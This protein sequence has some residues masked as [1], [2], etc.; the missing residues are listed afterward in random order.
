MHFSIVGLC[1]LS[2]SYSVK[3][4]I[5]SFIAQENTALQILEY[6]D[7]SANGSNLLCVCVCVFNSGTTIFFLNSHYFH[8]V[9]TCVTVFFNECSRIL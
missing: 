3:V 2:T 9:K 6:Y 7:F 1:I 4:W 5:K 8:C